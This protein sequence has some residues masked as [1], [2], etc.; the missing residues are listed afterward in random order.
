MRRRRRGGDRRSILGARVLTPVITCQGI[1][2]TDWALAT[3]I[4]PDSRLS[5]QLV[6]LTLCP[7]PRPPTA[8]EIQCVDHTSSGELQLEAVTAAAVQ[9]PTPAIAGEPGHGRRVVHF[10]GV[11]ERPRA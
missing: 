5:A 4:R 6:E 3:T 10:D 9:T 11:G 1:D 8:G 7:T 2:C